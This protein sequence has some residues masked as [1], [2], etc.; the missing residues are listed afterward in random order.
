[1]HTEPQIYDSFNV[2]PVVFHCIF[3]K[4]VWTLEPT[5][6]VFEL[7]LPLTGCVAFPHVNFIGFISSFVNWDDYYCCFSKYHKNQDG[8]SGLCLS[9]SHFGTVYLNCA[10]LGGWLE[11]RSLRPAWTTWQKPISTKDRKISWAW[12]C[13]PVVP[14]NQEAEMGGH[15]SPGGWGH[16][17]PWLHHCTPAWVTE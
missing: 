16:S 13:T 3:I 15:L 14:T 1:M 9:S 10:E 6:P 12:W 4:R 2:L 8:H 11:P 17:K 5:K 7:T